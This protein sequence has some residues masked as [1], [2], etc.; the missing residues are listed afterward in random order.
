MKHSTYLLYEFIYIL[1]GAR[2]TKTT[3][4]AKP[5][6]PNAQTAMRTTV[7]TIPSALLAAAKHLLNRFFILQ[8]IIAGISSLE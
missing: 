7:F 2:Q 8:N 4:T 6:P 3:F 1:L 5:D